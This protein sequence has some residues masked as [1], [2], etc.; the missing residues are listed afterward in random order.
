[1]KEPTKEYLGKL[2]INYPC[3]VDAKILSALTMCGDAIIR[4]PRTDRVKHWAR[5]RDIIHKQAKPLRF[6]S[7]GHQ[8]PGQD[9]DPM[10]PKSK[11]R[12][13]VKRVVPELIK[14]TSQDRRYVKRL[15]KLGAS[16]R[17]IA[18]ALGIPED[19]PI[20]CEHA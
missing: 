5:L 16:N 7:R 14:T 8:H 3:V 6:L 19:A 10:K 12:R 15:R 18:I 17:E 11:Q 20:L 1:M 2:E 9:K 13:E 4:D